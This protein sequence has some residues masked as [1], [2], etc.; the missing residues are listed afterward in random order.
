[1][2]FVYPPPEMAGDE[3]HLY[4][5][6]LLNAALASN[7]SRYGD[8][9]A[10]PH[11]DAMTFQRAVAG[12]QSGVGWSISYRGQPTMI[13]SSGCVVLGSSKSA[14]RLGRNWC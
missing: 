4:Y 12:V 11:G 9:V 3:R 1:M 6:Q 13:W 7:S 5:W 14:I 2:R 10:M 8:Y